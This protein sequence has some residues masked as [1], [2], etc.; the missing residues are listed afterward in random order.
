M[1]NIAALQ[2]YFTEEF[3]PREFAE[4]LHSV[5][6]DYVRMACYAGGEASPKTV[7]W[8]IDFLESLRR[9]VLECE[10]DDPKE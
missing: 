3:A 8:N 4:Q 2:K 10:T 7:A 6:T 9:V 5:M 1:I